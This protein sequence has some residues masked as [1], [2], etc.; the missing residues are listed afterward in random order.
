[1]IA[2]I[3]RFDLLIIGNTLRYF[4]VRAKSFLRFWDNPFYNLRSR[5]NE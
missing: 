2:S 4:I 3:C 1:M 5:I